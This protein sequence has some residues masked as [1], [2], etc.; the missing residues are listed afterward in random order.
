MSTFPARLLRCVVLLLLVSTFAF[1]SAYNARPKLLVVIIIDQFP[2]DYLER[3]HDQFA[4]G[5]FR[6]LMERGADFAECYYEYA[7]THTAPGHATLFTGTYSN[8]HGIIGNEW[9]DP[10]KKKFVGSVDDPAYQIIGVENGGTGA[11]PHNLLAST[12]GDELKLATQGK[13][14]VYSLSLK[15]RA[16]I[17]PG[18]HAADFAFWWDKQTGKIVSSTYYAKQLPPWVT[19]FNASKRNEKYLNLDWKDV[20][21]NVLRTTKPGQKDADSF[22]DLVGR[23][24]F[25]ND[26]EFEFAREIVTN[27]KL[28]QGDVTDFLAISVSSFDILGHQVGPDSPELAA[29]TLALD[30]Q[31]Q[32]FFGFLGRQVGLAN[33]WIA[34]SADHGVAPLPDAAVAMHIPAA[35]L[36]SAELRQQLTSDLSKIHV[37]SNPIAGIKWSLI[38]LNEPSFTAVGMKEAEAERAVGEAVLARHP[39]FRGYYTKSQLRAGNVPNNDLGHKYLN[40]FSE[41][42]GWYV[43]LL[44]PPFVTAFSEPKY[45]DNADHSMPYSYDTHVPLLFFGLPFQPGVYRTHAEPVDLAVTLTSLLGINKPTHAVG[46]VLTEALTSEPRSAGTSRATSSGE[47]AH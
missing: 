38:Y 14:R 13:S 2:G 8:G 4:P 42:P 44:P 27:E 39:E 1:G 33:V 28:G 18:G 41:V 36:D 43:E 26:Y 25:A 35:H 12:I 6:M 46:R 23:T 45:R 5:G 19:A 30:R 16:S 22:Y 47:R 9:W 40:S 21:G 11:S 15:D 24:P 17:L 7:N 37:E 32:D 29:M 20:R 31:L 34:L 10:N 3:Y